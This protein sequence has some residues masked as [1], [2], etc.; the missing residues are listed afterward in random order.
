MKNET[1]PREEKQTMPV[2]FEQQ[3][4]VANAG[5]VDQVQGI[6]VS[7][8]GALWATGLLLLVVGGFYEFYAWGDAEG[9]RGLGL[10]LL[11]TIPLVVAV[12]HV[13]RANRLHQPIL[14][15]P[16]VVLLL[17]SALVL[18]F[19]LYLPQLWLKLLGPFFALGYGLSLLWYGA[20][21]DSLTYLLIAC[22]CVFGAVVSIP[23]CYS[24]SPTLGGGIIL[25]VGIAVLVSAYRLHKLREAR[26]VARATAQRKQDL[27]RE[28]AK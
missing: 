7:L 12:V 4:I 17:M 14:K 25:A 24:L 19:A 3:E 27:S 28:A 16:F 5:S 21:Y 9:L 2:R 26:I 8:L 10:S 1:A 15:M 6:P 13:R 22:A 18:P 20:Y 23:S 11:V